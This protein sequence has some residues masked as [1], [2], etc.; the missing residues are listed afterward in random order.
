VVLVTFLFVGVGI[1]HRE[2]HLEAAVENTFA[3]TPH[4]KRCEQSGKRNAAADVKTRRPALPELT[5]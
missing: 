4:T 5:S 1:D 3:P 2:I